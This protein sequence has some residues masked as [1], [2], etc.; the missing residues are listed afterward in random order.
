MAPRAGGAALLVYR[1][2]R[3]RDFV[4]IG[5]ARSVLFRQ[6]PYGLFLIFGIAFGFCRSAF[7]VVSFVQIVGYRVVLVLVCWR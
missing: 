7:A 6:F 2:L 5:V 1:C 3:Q 4:I